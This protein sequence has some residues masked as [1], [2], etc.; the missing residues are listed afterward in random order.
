MQLSHIP[1]R[2]AVF[3]MPF[4][5]YIF[6]DVHD[7]FPPSPPCTSP[8]EPDAPNASTPGA[9][10]PHIASSNGSVPYIP[11][12]K[13]L[14]VIIFMELTAQKGKGDR[15]KGPATALELGT[16]SLSR[17]FSHASHG[18]RDPPF[19]IALMYRSQVCR[20]SA[21][22]KTCTSRLVLCAM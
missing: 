3:L 12:Q 2:A 20:Y 19:P 11:L 14:H 5:L 10:I 8:H 7:Q 1:S 16:Y 4:C 6:V 21:T 9:S 18:D 15:E 13:Y 17:S 22:L